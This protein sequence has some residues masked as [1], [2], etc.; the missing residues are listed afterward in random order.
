MQCNKKVVGTI[1]TQFAIN[2]AAVKANAFI[3]VF[4][5]TNNAY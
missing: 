1:T 2:L 3:S 4:Q 5:H